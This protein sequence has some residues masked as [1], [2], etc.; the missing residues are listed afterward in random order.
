MNWKS[1]L[2][3]QKG[4]IWAGEMS[5]RKCSLRLSV[6][7][8]TMGCGVVGVVK[9]ECCKGWGLWRLKVESCEDWGLRVVGNRIETT[10]H[11]THLKRTRNWDLRYQKAE[12][13]PDFFLPSKIERGLA[14][15]QASP[16]GQNFARKT[17][18]R[19]TYAH[20]VSTY[21]ERYSIVK[22]S[23]YSSFFSMQ[24]PIA[25]L[26]ALLD[27][28]YQ[29]ET[30]ISANLIL[31]AIESSII[32]P[33]LTVEGPR[34]HSRWDFSPPGPWE[35]PELTMIK[36]AKQCSPVSPIRYHQRG[37][38]DSIDVYM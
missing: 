26:P 23:S 25:P 19:R 31:A 18:N 22:A 6:Y 20:P 27:L 4:Q 38:P 28:L 37:Y 7:S 29:I 12:S 17:W 15:R 13:S 5:W 32:P 2:E 24:N 30:P 9:V 8:R 33:E 10:S 1:R 11:T 21:S 14:F 3:K 34:N 16:G 36:T 35:Q